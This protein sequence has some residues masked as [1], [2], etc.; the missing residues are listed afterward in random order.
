VLHRGGGVGAGAPQQ[1]NAEIFS[2]PYLVRGARPTIGS[3]PDHVAY[4]AE[5]RVATPDAGAVTSVS[6]IRTGA[7]THAFDENQR[8]Q[9]L[10]FTADAAG[11]TVKAPTSANRAPPGYYLLFILNGSAVPSVGKF[12][13]LN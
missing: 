7:A 3:V 4:G 8:F 13:R 6:L 5:F 10:S 12:V 1:N 11:L 9:R 2:P